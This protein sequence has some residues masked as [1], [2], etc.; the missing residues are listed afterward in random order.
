MSLHHEVTFF[1]AAVFRAEDVEGAF[2]VLVSDQR[3]LQMDLL[4]VSTE[5]GSALVARTGI[6]DRIDA[7]AAGGAHDRA[8]V[9][10]PFWVVEPDAGVAGAALHGL[11]SGDGFH[12]G[13]G[14][15]L[16][17]E[18]SRVAGIHRRSRPGR[19]TD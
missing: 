11:F 15:G 2:R 5:S 17:G 9:F 7:K 16:A 13:H 18:I 3:Q 4:G 10:R 6:K 19:W 12:D 1:Q 14:R 8:D